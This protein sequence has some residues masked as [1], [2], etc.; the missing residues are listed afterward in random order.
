MALDA[1]TGRQLWKTY[2]VDEP[3][4]TQLNAARRA[5][6]GARRR[7]GVE[8]PDR[9]SAAPGNV[10]IGTGDATTFPAAKT[11]D[12]VMAFDMSTGAV[13][14]SYQ[15]HENDSFLVGCQGD[16]RTENCPQVQGPDWDI[17]ASVI[18]RD[19]PGA[20]SFL[21]V[22]TK[23]GDIL[24]L[25]PDKGGALRW[26]MNV[27][28]H[29]CRKRPAPAK[30]SPQRCAVGIRRGRS[31]GVFRPDRRRDRGGRYQDGSPEVAGAPA[32]RRLP[33][34]VRLGHRR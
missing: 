20:G 7:I 31:D 6:L 32:R 30:R 4:P 22:G 13:K 24:A 21:L 29:A 18:L 26:R 10:Y 9:R 19:I 28:R 34:V 11:S 27:E 17:P 8:R 3:K 16:N 1:N 33:R 12:A 14:W 23:P 15:V 5:A 25:D 2:V